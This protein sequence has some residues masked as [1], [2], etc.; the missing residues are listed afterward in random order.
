ML[1]SVLSLSSIK[2][3]IVK[4]NLMN[5]ETSQTQ[6]QQIALKRIILSLK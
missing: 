2:G 4:V 5:L 6:D 3:L 1:D